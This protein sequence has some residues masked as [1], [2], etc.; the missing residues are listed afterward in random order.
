MLSDENNGLS[1][2]LSEVLKRMLAKQA[3]PDE[4]SVDN[5]SPKIDN[6]ALAEGGFPLRHCLKLTQMKGS[7]LE[8]AKKHLPK[9]LNGDS[10]MVLSG[11]RGRGKTQMATWWAAQ[12]T[13]HGKSPGRYTTTLDLIGDIKA[14]WHEGGR[15]RGTEA[16]LIKRYEKTPYL[17]LDEF[18]ERG[19]SDWEAQTLLGLVDRRYYSMKCTV[20]ICS[21]KS[22]MLSKVINSSIVDR[23]NE[24][25]DLIECDWSSYRTG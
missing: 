20:I 17:V 4:E 13:F 7:G 19:A 23:V 6:K 2:E 10:L 25:G 1:K 16:D 12:R 3:I 18:H 24:I 11:D 5:R 15:N 21:C 14:T 8:V 22:E 9:I